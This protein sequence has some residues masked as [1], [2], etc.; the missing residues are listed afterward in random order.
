[1]EFNLNHIVGC[2][3]KIVGHNAV[4][5][6]F[7]YLRYYKINERADKLIKEEHP[8]FIIYH[9]FR[10]RSLKRNE[11][12]VTIHGGLTNIPPAWMRNNNLLIGDFV[13]LIGIS[14][15]LLFHL[16]D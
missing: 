12:I 14:N 15:G 1:M 10:E 7:Q 6:P 9:P 13:Y 4:Y 3:I 5:I 8:K 16:R 11:K 2:P